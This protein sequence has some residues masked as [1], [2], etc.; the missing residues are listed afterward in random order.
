MRV[1]LDHAVGSRELPVDAALEHDPFEQDP[2]ET[3]AAGE[4]PA[5]EGDVAAPV[6]Q[7]DDRTY[8]NVDR[9]VVRAA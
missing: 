9:A 2:L 8:G 1:D 7:V 4:G 6:A 3:V 5:V